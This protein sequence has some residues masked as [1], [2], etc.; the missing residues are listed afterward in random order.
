MAETCQSVIDL[1]RETLNDDDKTRWPDPT[2]I[3][4]LRNGLD[5]LLTLRPDLFHGI[6][7]SFDSGTLLVGSDWPI[8]DRYARLGADYVIFRCEMLDD[9][10]V[11]GER[12][13]LSKKFF[14]EQAILG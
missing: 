2:C 3:K 1:A 8:D 10:H 6:L 9:Q 12:A 13:D 4:F 14:Q 11:V 5:A 7:N